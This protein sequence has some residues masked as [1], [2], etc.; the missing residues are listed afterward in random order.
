[1]RQEELR[2]G[3][4]RL[5]RHVGTAHRPGPCDRV[6]RLVV[7]Q[8]HLGLM[9]LGG[10]DHGRA[11]LDGVCDDLGQ[12]GLCARDVAHPEGAQDHRLRQGGDH[13]PQPG[14][15]D[16]RGEID[17]GDVVAL[18]W[19]RTRP[20]C[21]VGEGRTLRAGCR[22]PGPPPGGPGGRQWRCAGGGEALEGP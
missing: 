10:D 21:A 22:M 20:I 7:A 12:S 2:L 14:G 17:D 1:M 11:R 5:Q 6:A 13:G 8:P 4:G 16:S 9:A 18:V 19:Q 3:V 15:G